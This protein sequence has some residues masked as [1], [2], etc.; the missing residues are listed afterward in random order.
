MPEGND[1]R[2]FLLRAWRLARLHERD[3]TFAV[4]LEDRVWLVTVADE[5]TIFLLLSV[6]T[7]LYYLVHPER[8]ASRIQRGNAQLGS[9]LRYQ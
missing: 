4:T 5:G 2:V 7:A 6:V 9:R 1:R 3:L 8:L